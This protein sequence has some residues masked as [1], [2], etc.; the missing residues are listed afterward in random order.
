MEEKKHGQY[1][2]FNLIC[3]LPYLKMLGMILDFT[4]KIKNIH[5]D[6]RFKKSIFGE[7]HINNKIS[8]FF[9][10]TNWIKKEGSLLRSL[11]AISFYLTIYG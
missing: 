9:I 5:N 6:N 7:I 8:V 1:R 3:P 4:V 11:A 2:R 10:W